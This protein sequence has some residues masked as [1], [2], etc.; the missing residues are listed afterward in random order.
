L[1]NKRIVPED[2]WSQI[3]DLL[4]QDGYFPADVLELPAYN[5]LGEDPLPGI[6]S[7]LRKISQINRLRQSYLVLR[8]WMKRRPW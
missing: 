7:I 3:F 6:E 2:E 1:I 8:D 5:G 4:I